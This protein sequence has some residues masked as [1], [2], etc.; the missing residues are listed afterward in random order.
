ML[1][2]LAFVL[3]ANTLGHGFL[4]DDR[5][6][7]TE[8]A[9]TKQ[10]L[11]GIPKILSRESFSGYLAGKETDA[12][13]TGGR[14][15]PLS[16][17]FFAV[18]HQ[19]FGDNAAVF[20][21]FAVLLFALNCLFLYRF[22]LLALK[23]LPVQQ[24]ALLVS[25]VTALLFAAHPVH[26]EVVANIK[27]CDEQLALLAGLG[28]LYA[29]LRAWDSGAWKWSL[30]SALLFFLACMAKENAL[31]LLAVAPL[32]LW[33][34]REANVGTALRRSWPVAAVFAVY[35]IVRGAALD[36][37]F[38]GQVMHDPLNNPF[39]KSDGRQWVPFSAD[40]K[41]ATILYTLLEYLRLL[42]WPWPLT[43]D[44]YP[45]KIAV[46]TFDRLPVIASS[47]LHVLLLAFAIWGLIRRNLAAF[48]VLFYALTLS[49][50]ANIFLPV[51][52]S[53]AERFLFMPSVGFCFAITM[54]TVPQMTRNKWVNRIVTTAL[55]AL[56]VIWG[57]A[58]VMRNP[59][60]A[61]EEQL[62]QADLAV[63]SNSAKLRNDLGTALLAK[64]LKTSGKSERESL[65]RE[66]E[67]HLRKAV[68]LHPTYFDAFLAYGACV[69]YLNQFDLS[70]EAYRG[71]TKINPKDAKAKLG[72]A[73]A[74]RYGGEFYAQDKRDPARAMGYLTESWHLNP[75]TATAT[76]L[77]EQYG[78]R[79]QPREA[80]MWLEQALSLAPGDARLQE[81]LNTARATSGSDAQT[82]RQGFNTFSPQ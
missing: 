20:H 36:W 55:A 39:L 19:F 75:D 28:A 38:A 23:P 60:W 56:V 27:S 50:T 30:S 45:F 15:R 21:G 63:S 46:Q 12:R 53:M 51:G 9:W 58:T 54:F 70:I 76:R 26:T 16:I 13:L 49:L 77:S 2:V 80:V 42:V 14:Y 47:I 72:L 17:V 61:S 65:L 35:I 33:F 62:L 78:E 69:F 64:A 71:A 1:F 10:G 32:T 43:H 48:G 7:I 34:F 40:E 81:A 24:T 41:A 18:L 29:L 31:T 57:A 68:E 73:Y 67:T 44:Y 59:A 11:S 52:V 74:L 6:V 66:A 25:F 22:L 4:V 3:Y 82:T 5:I 8:N 79:G 37:Q